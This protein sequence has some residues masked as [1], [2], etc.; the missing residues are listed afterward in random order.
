M[1]QPEKITARILQISDG[2][3]VCVSPLNNQ[4]LHEVMNII[5]P[6]FIYIFL[7]VEVGNIS[8]KRAL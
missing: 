3:R 1:I 2:P 6:Y 4:K 5:E 8:Q 7:A